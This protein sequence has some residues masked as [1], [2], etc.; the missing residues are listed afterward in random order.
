METAFNSLNYNT[1]MWHTP[2]FKMEIGHVGASGYQQQH[3]NY[4]PVNNHELLSKLGFH[5]FIKSC[6][7]FTLSM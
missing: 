6:N 2:N 5:I 3:D 1:L 4:Q 7:N